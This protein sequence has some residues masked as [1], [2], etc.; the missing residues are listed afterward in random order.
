MDVHQQHGTGRSD[1][2]ET[3]TERLDRNWAEL[4][5]ELRVTQTGVQILTGFLLTVPFQQRFAELD[6]YQRAVYLVLVV[7]ATV[8]TAFIV[9]PV[10]LHR[11][12]FR[13]GLKRELVDSADRLSR[14]GLAA[15]GLVL[16]GGTLLIFDVVVNRVAGVVAGTVMLGTLLVVWLAVPAR[17]V[18]RA[19]AEPRP[20]AVAPR[21]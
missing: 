18:R 11:M 4:L 3:P 8:A 17:L 2:H 12:L 20:T 21:R 14:V 10:S 7:L 5:Q 6:G 16:A 9:A 15:L 1:R 19:R 13:R